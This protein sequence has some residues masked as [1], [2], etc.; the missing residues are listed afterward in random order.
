MK[1]A[2]LHGTSL[3]EN[4]VTVSAVMGTHQPGNEASHENL[5][6]QADEALYR[7]KE[8]GRNCVR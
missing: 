4:V 8:A 2:I 1:L 5:L 3:V 7:A 6:Q